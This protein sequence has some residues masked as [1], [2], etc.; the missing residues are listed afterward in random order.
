MIGS[1]VAVTVALHLPEYGARLVLSMV[2]IA[3]GKR[4]T[5]ELGEDTADRMIAFTRVCTGASANKEIALAAAEAR[6]AH[7][8][9]SADAIAFATA[10]A[11]DAD[12]PTCDRR[13]EGLPGALLVLES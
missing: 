4:P 10:R 11:H 13:C 6:R 7:G 3:L 9:A 2:Q 12:L 8:R 1:T 5:R